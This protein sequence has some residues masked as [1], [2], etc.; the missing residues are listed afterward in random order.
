MEDLE[1]A[2]QIYLFN[3]ASI[4]IGAHGAAFTNIIFCKQKTKVIEIIPENHPN[5]KCERIS[6]ILKLDYN[7]ITTKNSDFE[8]KMNFN[9]FLDEK[10]INKILTSIDLY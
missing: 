4:V 3:E 9:I 5:K 8:K 2:K 7:R 1:F 6:E 10:N